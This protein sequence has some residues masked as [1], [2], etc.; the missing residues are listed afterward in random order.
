MGD[1]REKGSTHNGVLMGSDIF[2]NH[3]F[4]SGVDCRSLCGI[5][6]GRAK[7][8]DTTAAGREDLKSRR[9]IGDYEDLQ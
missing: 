8:S 2:P 3:L 7:V 9:W 5:A 6:R 4:L 1:Q